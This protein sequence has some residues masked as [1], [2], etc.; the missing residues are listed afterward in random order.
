MAT[1]EQVNP[2]N[3]ASPQTALPANIVPASLP[4]TNGIP[5]HSH[6]SAFRPRVVDNSVPNFSA[7]LL[8]VHRGSIPAYNPDIHPIN[9]RLA[10]P[11]P[12]LLPNQ[13]VLPSQPTMASNSFRTYRGDTFDV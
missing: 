5:A 8:G 12:T 4:G 1:P 9:S 2:W 11:R 10:Q 6:L 3:R 7:N 13:Q